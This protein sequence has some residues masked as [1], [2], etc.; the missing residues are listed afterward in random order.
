[1]KIVSHPRDKQV[2][3]IFIGINKARN[4][5]FRDGSELL[6]NTIHFILGKETRNL[7]R[8]QNHVDVFQETFFLHFIVR[9]EEH[10]RRG[11]AS[12][13]IE[14]LQIIQQ[15][16]RVVSL[17]NDQLECLE[18]LDKRRK[19]SQR[20]LSTSSH[21]YK[22]GI[23]SGCVN[24]ARDSHQMFQRKVK[25]HQGHGGLFV[26]FIVLIH[27]EGHSRLQGL[28]A[29]NGFVDVGN[30]SVFLRIF[31]L[32]CISQ[33]VDKECLLHGIFTVDFIGEVFLDHFLQSVVEPL[34]ILHVDEFISNHTSHFM[35]PKL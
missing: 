10:D 23:S 28:K 29:F 15:V 21:T 20:L 11:E 9:E 31:W 14:H 34:L 8:S 32:L 26:L 30:N 17:G 22:E 25:E 6:T 19:T 2:V 5:L 1:M 24:N 12:H 35:R 27:E 13:A 7:S 18:P 4:C 33:E 3:E 16:T